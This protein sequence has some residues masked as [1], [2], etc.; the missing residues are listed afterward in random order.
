MTTVVAET[1]PRHDPPSELRSGIGYWVA[2]LAS[3]MRFDY[4]RVRQW[5]PM[6][7]V[8]QAFMGAG[9]ALLYGFFYPHV[10]A[11]RALY[12]T[13]GAP[14][15]ALIPVGF[16]MLPGTVAEQKLEGTFDYIWSLPAPRSAQAASTFTLFTL[17]AL[18]G[19]VLALIVAAWRYD[20]HLAPSPLL[21]PAV[22]LCALMAITVGYG[23]AMAI[24]NPMVTNVIT[25]AL[26]FVVLLFSPIVYPASQLPAWFASV[27]YFLPFY[28]MA[29]VI[30]AGLTFGIVAHATTSF[31]VLAAWTL[32]GAGAT[33]FVVGRRR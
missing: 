10:T 12:I 24:A 18:P 32:A 28:N 25:N 13:T 1:R 5:V 8:I 20:V 17:F 9:M 2:S 21:A 6:M 3:M 33:A 7:I 27:H 4:G 22:L 30:R 11:M 19:S 29:V 15:L 26:M 31:V 16:V 23:M 14:T